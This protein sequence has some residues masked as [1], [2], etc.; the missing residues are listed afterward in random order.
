MIY[1]R[2]QEASPNRQ[3]YEVVFFDKAGRDVATVVVS[4]VELLMGVSMMNDQKVIIR[5]FNQTTLEFEDVEIEE[6]TD[7]E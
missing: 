3:L 7:G 6:N 2:I 5:K 1:K 4:A